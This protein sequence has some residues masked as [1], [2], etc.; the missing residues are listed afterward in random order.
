MDCKDYICSGRIR[1]FEVTD[2]KKHNTY[3]TIFASVCMLILILDGRTALHG[4]REGLS[5][6][7]DALIPSLFPY[8]FLSILLI[9]SLSGQEIRVLHPI[10]RICKIPTG[11]ESILAISFLGGYPA[12]AQCVSVMKKQGY[13]TDVQAFHMLS[14]CNN[15]GPAF[16]FGILGSMFS[17][18]STPWLLWLVQ[19][20]SALLVGFLIPASAAASNILPIHNKTSIM[21]AFK[22]S[23]KAMGS[24]CGWVVLMRI[25]LAFIETW[26][27]RFFSQPVQIL[28]AGILE[29]SNGCIRISELESEGLRFLIASLLLSF[30]GIC[31][32]LQTA[33]VA[34]DIPIKYYLLGKVLQCSISIFLSSLLQ[35]VFPAPMRYDCRIGAVIAVAIFTLT[36]SILRHSKNNSRIPAAVGV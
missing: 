4:A 10:A 28:I 26:F 7:L 36:V 16:V 22:Q 30:G 6:C 25:F 31:V 24:I 32:T 19:I 21:N 1:F 9:G 17:A 2:L 33:S 27:L 13:L 34:D 20:V 29:L 11:T 18:G 35:V 12:G 23:L 3:I 15:A 5:L 8:L 14:F